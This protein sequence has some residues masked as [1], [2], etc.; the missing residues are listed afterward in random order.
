MPGRVV[1]V[2]AV[3]MLLAGCSKAGSAMTQRR[4]VSL[5]DTTTSTPT[6]D[7]FSADIA[8]VVCE[9]DAVSL[10]D[11]VVR[12]HRDGVHF[13][14][15]NR[16]GAWGVE[17]HEESWASGTAEGIE[18]KGKKTNDTS[19][20]GPG[21]VA[22]ASPEERFV[23][24]RPGRSQRQTHDRGSGGAVRAVGPGLWLRGAV[25]DEARGERGRRSRGGVPAGAKGQGVR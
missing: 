12:A 20:I 17:L 16:G 22:V 19:A 11:P 10:N 24:P 8:R 5:K 2:S 7:A 9:K 21:N 18:L 1:A 3:L 15:E 6:R 4:S 23:L 13:L 14:I 25:P